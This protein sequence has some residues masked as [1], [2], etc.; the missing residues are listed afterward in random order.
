MRASSATSSSI[1]SRASSSARYVF[2]FSESLAQS[3]S[4]TP[5]RWRDENAILCSIWSSEKNKGTEIRP[6]LAAE[7]GTRRERARPFSDRD[8]DAEVETDSASDGVEECE[9]HDASDCG[10]DSLLALNA[11][12]NGD[13]VFA[14]AV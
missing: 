8:K 14:L 2:R 13:E 11:R 10:E 12:E 6:L 3:A 4:E 9:F 7:G 5:L 1:R